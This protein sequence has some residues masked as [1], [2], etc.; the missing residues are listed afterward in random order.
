MGVTKQLQKL[1]SS[2]GAR[3]S[4]A[5]S[6]AGLFVNVKGLV[7]GSTLTRTAEGSWGA[8]ALT[9]SIQPLAFL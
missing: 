6:S 4:L 3:Y 7:L 2:F 8:P 1:D 5:D 9:L